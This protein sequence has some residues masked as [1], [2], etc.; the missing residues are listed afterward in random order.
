MHILKNRGRG[1]RAPSPA[2]S[3]LVTLLVLTVAGT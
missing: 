2:R 1:A 3:F